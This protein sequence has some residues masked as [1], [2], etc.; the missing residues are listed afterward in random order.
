MHVQN[1]HIMIYYLQS[2]S[3]VT[4]Q[5]ESAGL[6]VRDTSEKNRG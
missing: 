4:Q 2:I 3:E 1:N 6:R 5:H